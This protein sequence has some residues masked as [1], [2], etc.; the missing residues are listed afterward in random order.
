MSASPPPSATRRPRRWWRRL[1]WVFLSVM[2]L[3]AAL[4]VGSWWWRVE[5]VNGFLKDPSSVWRV[6]IAQLDWEGGRLVGRGIVVSHADQAEPVFSADAVSATGDVEALKAGR[7]GDVVAV[8]PKVFWRAGLRSDPASAKPPLTGPMVEWNSLSLNG[9]EVDVAREGDWSFSGKVSGAGGGGAWLYEGRLALAPQDVSVKDGV[10]RMILPDGMVDRLEVRAEQVDLSGSVE[11]ATGT[12][13][14]SKARLTRAK[15]L[16]EGGAA[17]PVKQGSGA[18]AANAQ[19]TEP[20]E[21]EGVSVIS[22][23]VISDL[24]APGLEAMGRFPW[25]AGLRGNLS[26]GHFQA[27]DGLVFELGGI[28][29]AG[30]SADLPTGGKVPAL[31]VSGRMTGGKPVLEKLD[32][33]GVEIPD[34]AELLRL[35]GQPVPAGVAGYFKAEGRLKDLSWDGEKVVSGSEQ[36]L[37]L[38]G[39]EVAGPGYGK[40]SLEKLVLGAVPDEMRDARRLRRLEVSKPVAD[41]EIAATPPAV[42]DAALEAEKSPVATPADDLSGGPAG[43]KGIAAAAAPLLPPA[44]VPSEVEPSLSVGPD[45]APERPAWEGWTADLL[46]VTEGSFAATLPQFSGARVTSA[47]AVATTPDEAPP[48]EGEAVAGP[49]YQVSLVKPVLIHPAYPDQPV[50]L[51]GLIQLTASAAGLW[52]KREIDSLTLAGS[53]MQIGEALFRLVNALPTGPATAVPPPRTS[54]AAPVEEPEKTTTG[55]MTRPWRLKQF[56]LE[57]TLIQLDHLGDG[58]RLDIP[59]KRQEFRDLPLDSTA[60]AKVNRVYKIE[61]PNITLY[62]PFSA[63]QKVAVLD[64]NYIQFTPAGLMERRLDRVDLMLPS[65]YAGQPL[66][67][68]VDAARQRFTAMASVPAPAPLPLL[69]DTESRSPTVLSALASVSPAEAAEAGAEWEIPFYTESGKVFVAPKGF[70]WPNLPVI[71]FRNAR[72]AK[73]K[74]VP[75]LLHGESFHGELSIEPG[76]YEFPEYKVRLRLSDRGRIVFNT[77]QKD[78]D[79]NLTEVFEKNTLIFRQ[80]QI[81]EAW[82]SITYDARGIYAKFGGMTCGG[83][84]SGGVNLYMDELYT[85]D[86]WVSM[87]GVGMEPLTKKLT[88]DTFRM[89]G[90]IDELTVKAYGDTTTL[91][92]ATLDLHVTKPGQ[93]HLLALDELK[94]R[95]DALGGVSADLGQISLATLR[96]FPYTGCSGQLKLFGTEGVGK[97]ALTGPTGSRTF[98]LKLHDYRAKMPKTAAPF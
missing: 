34:A 28:H 60:L 52:G 20:S 63:G 82:L 8:N 65:L 64:T 81:D 9:G 2:V 31:E 80:L 24:A 5:L 76:W 71:P 38:S 84:I 48:A 83:T 46:T 86:G 51:A 45:A 78:R 59:V 68:F 26:V 93:M 67:D 53:R 37:T 23:V 17:G 4:G 13:E 85:W 30:A 1:G 74:P 29:L 70:P 69:V 27:G 54:E 11:A 35:L 90:P 16:A 61:V 87:V 21:D 42:A 43:E 49:H 36:S 18:T 96:D 25:E 22:G 15:V 19:A 12:L 88:P 98:N 92:Q 32:F 77:P 3:V 41:L 72:D 66:F 55:V 89:S 62:S 58:R 75:F 79:N 40:A 39:L 97:L 57:D 33:S 10:Y 95:I 47:F 44:A 14:V 50:A 56:V 73:G 6:R 94:D 91:Y 7:L